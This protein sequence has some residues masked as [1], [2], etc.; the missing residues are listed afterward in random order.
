MFYSLFIFSSAAL[1]DWISERKENYISRMITIR[2]EPKLCRNGVYLPRLILGQSKYNSEWAPKR[3]VFIGRLTE[4][5]G[6]NIFLTLIKSEELKKFEILIVVPSDP[7]IEIRSRI[8]FTISKSISEIEFKS[9]DI[10]IYPVINSSSYVESISINVLEM[11]ALGIPS[12]V[13]IN[14][15]GTWPELVTNGLVIEVDWSNLE[16]VSSLIT[17]MKFYLPRDKVL[18][19]RELLDVKNNLMTVLQ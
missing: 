2:R 13:T 11:A 12:L 7:S 19:T 1:A 17:K 14:G 6:F 5:K 3:L 16:M 4:W 9:G 18:K 8:T 15:S 10:H